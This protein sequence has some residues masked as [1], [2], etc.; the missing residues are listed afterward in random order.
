MNRFVSILALGATLVASSAAFAGEPTGRYQGAVGSVPDGV[1]Q[2]YFDHFSNGRG[3]VTAS[4]A[5][6]IPAASISD[7]AFALLQPHGRAYTV[8][9][10]SVPT[11]SDND[12]RLADLFK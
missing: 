5:E 8:T 2:V 10:F 1:E 4:V 12:V 7:H 11:T 6:N 3:G 9:A